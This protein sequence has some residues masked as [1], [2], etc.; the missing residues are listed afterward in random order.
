MYHAEMKFTQAG[1]LDAY[2]VLRA[3]T[4]DGARSLGLFNS[5]GSLTA[6]KLA[7]MVLYP[8]GVDYDQF[9][10]LS[11]S[12]NPRFVVRGGRVFEAGNMVEHWPV[13][14]RKQVLPKINAE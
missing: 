7:D 8:E 9:H 14:G 10:D 6:G 13:K 5:I 12:R 3:A 11:P 1:G 2:E 4:R